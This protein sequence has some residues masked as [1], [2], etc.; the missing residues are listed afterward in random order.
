MRDLLVTNVE[1]FDATSESAS[2]TLTSDA[3]EVVAFC[4]PC[5]CEPGASVPNRLH[6]LDTTKLQSPFLDDWP[7]DERELAAKERLHR[8]GEFAYG[9]CGKVIDPS[10]GLVLVQGFVFD[11]G[12]VPAGAEFV[13]FEV[14]R[15]D[16]P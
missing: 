1:R 12:E 7:D 3:G 6:V 16:L 10:A 15:L 9:G 8:T 5:S 13:E 4:F 2:V 11:F 14:T